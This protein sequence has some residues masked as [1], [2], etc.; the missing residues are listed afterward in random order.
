M[1]PGLGLSA[2]FTYGLVNR[3][4]STAMTWEAGLSCVL[5]AGIAMLILSITFL[6]QVSMRYV[7]GHI[8]LGTIIGIGFLL[9]T[10]GFESC[11]LIKDGE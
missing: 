3:K 5:F 8:K 10:I 4:D 2:Y 11:G 7:P 6:V 1:A 9:A